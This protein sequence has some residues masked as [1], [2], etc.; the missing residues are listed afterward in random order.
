MKHIL[1]LFCLLAS[2][3]LNA[4]RGGGG[5]ASQRGQGDASSQ[6]GRNSQDRTP[7]KFDAANAAGMVYYDTDQVIKKLKIKKNNQLL[8]NVK[9]AISN[10]HHKLNEIGLANKDNFDSL[11]VYMNDIMKALQVGGDRSRMQDI[12]F[13][14]REKL[15][16]V[17]RSVM[18]ED[19]KLNETITALLDEKQLKRWNNYQNEIKAKL[20]PERGNSQIRGNSGNNRQGGA[21]RMQGGGVGGGRQ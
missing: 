9:K 7:V 4:Q 21:Q 3:S 19:I 18:Q 6:G 13:S 1:L 14:V 16:P 8:L 5:G 10:Y 11:N 2:V 17:R 12:R 20:N 15:R